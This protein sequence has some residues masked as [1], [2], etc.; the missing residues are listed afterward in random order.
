MC[1][2]PPAI[3]VSCK[4]F[5]FYKPINQYLQGA[6]YTYNG[7]GDFW[8]V[9]DDTDNGIAVQ[10]RIDECDGGTKATCIAGVA[11][12][13]GVNGVNRHTVIVTSLGG[14]LQATVD[15]MPASSATDL[16]SAA[17]TL[18]VGTS[19][20]VESINGVK[21]DVTLDE[22]VIGVGVAIMS[23]LEGRVKGLYGNYDGD[24][25]NDF[26]GSDGTNYDAS[27]TDK[28]LFGFGE[29]WRVASS[30]SLF[31]SLGAAPDHTGWTPTFASDIAKADDVTAK[32]S[33]AG[34]SGKDLANCEFDVQVSGDDKFVKINERAA[35]FMVVKNTQETSDTF[36][37]N[38]LT[39]EATTT[40]GAIGDSSSATHITVD[41]ATSVAIVA[42]ALLVV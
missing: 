4:M 26:Q 11:I 32:C 22:G 8:L 36:S 21:I 19:I 33:A 5:N 12:A 18:T 38:A 27:S 24:P 40:S 9:R 10:V 2:T 34:L 42:A 30:D 7:K 28:D 25:T 23:D 3:N 35:N 39:G 15:G 37:N 41:A 1:G 31:S 14:V 6:S 17:D 16:G 29:S 20:K 13:T